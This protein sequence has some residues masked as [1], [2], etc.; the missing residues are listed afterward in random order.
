MA[1]EVTRVDFFQGD[2]A[3]N[4]ADGGPVLLRNRYFELNPQLS[5]DGV[6]LLVRPGM[7]YLTTVGEGPIRGLHTEEGLFQGNLFVASYDKLFRLAPDLTQ[8]LLYTGL[9]NP[10]SG[11]V[12][13]TGTAPIGTVPEFLFFADGRN[14]FVYVADGYATGTLA[15]TPANND[16]VRTDNTYYQFTNA[17]VDAGAPAGTLANPWKVAL[18]GSAAIA[19][20]NLAAAIS[21]NGTPGTEYST[22]LTTANPAVKVIGTTSTQVVVQSN[23]PGITGNS[24]ITTETGAGLGWTQGGTLTGGGAQQVR[25][26]QMPEDVGAFDVA[27]INSF[28]IVLP[29]QE[30]E[31]K[32]RFYWIRP[33]ETTVDPTD[34]A[35]AE[36]SPDE[37]LGV[38]VVGDTFYLPGPGS[39]EVWYVSQDPTKRMQRLQGV[40]FD[41]GT[42]EGTATAIHGALMVCGADGSVFKIV[43]GAPQRVSQPGIA[44]EIREAIQEQ[45]F[46]TI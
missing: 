4:V 46:L 15:G 44:E 1:D 12:N 42:W 32:G 24:I 21:A 19:L 10:E 40:V 11:V 43:G 39:T 18:G 34:F 28:V 9:Q 7:R 8:T 30:G 35:T 2:Y 20:S 23:I 37:V 5:E 22:A 31:Y 27:T 38:E 26:V 13:M 29:T 36:R 14:L 25:V 41:R 6:S 45:R 33:G 16:V 17:S 3:R